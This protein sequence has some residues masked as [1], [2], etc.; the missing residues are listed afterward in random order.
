MNFQYRYGMSTADALRHLYKDGGGGI[1]GLTRFYR[2][3]FPALMQ[4]RPASTLRQT[5]SSAITRHRKKTMLFPLSFLFLLGN[6]SS[7][8]GLFSPSV[9]LCCAGSFGEVR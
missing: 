9:R 7:L 8:T 4:V 3:Y 2:G 6:V 5:P 1:T